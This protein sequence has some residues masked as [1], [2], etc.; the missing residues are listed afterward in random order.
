VRVQRSATWLE[1]ERVAPERPFVEPVC[2]VRNLDPLP[3]QFREPF[4]DRVVER[5]GD[6]VVAIP[7]G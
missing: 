4:V 6:P 7:C 3:E 1:P 2:L 5:C